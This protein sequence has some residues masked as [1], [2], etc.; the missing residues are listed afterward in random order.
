MI[1]IMYVNYR[2]R[3]NLHHKL[4]TGMTFYK[5]ELQADIIKVNTGRS[6]TYVKMVTPNR[7]NL[8]PALNPS[9]YFATNCTNFL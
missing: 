6:N 4:T 1:C 5:H 3:E 9:N 7:F 2:E 8:V